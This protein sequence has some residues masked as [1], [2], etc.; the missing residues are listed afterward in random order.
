MAKKKKR[1]V[2][3]RTPINIKAGIVIFGIIFLYV[4]INVIIY[5]ATERVTYYEVIK[6]SVA[7]DSQYSYTAIALRNESVSYAESS[8]YI[9][10]YARENSRVSKNTTL[11]SIDQSGKINELLAQMSDEEKNL[12]DDNITT[13]KEQL[14]S[15]ITNYDEMNYGSVYDFKSSLQGTVVELINM[16]AL[17][18]IYNSLGSTQSEQFQICKPGNSGIVEYTIDNFENLT[19][20]KLKASYFDKANY[21]SARI[22]SGDLVEEGAPIYKTATQEEW[23]L[24]IPLSDEDAKAYENAIAVNIRFKKDNTFVT[25]NFEIVKGSDKK[26]YGI[27]TLQKYMI[28]YADERFLDIEIT[29]R[30][31]RTGTGDHQV[32]TVEKLEGGIEGLKVPKKSVISKDFYVIPVGYKTKGGD[33]EGYGFIKRVYDKSKATDVFTPVSITYQTDEY[34]YVSTD[35]FDAG[36]EVILPAKNINKINVDTSPDNYIA[37]GNNEEETTVDVKS[38]TDTY[39]VT[40]RQTL[41]GVYN[42]NNG[43]TKFVCVEILAETGDYFIIKSTNTYGLIIYDHIILNGSKVKENQVIFQ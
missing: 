22:E 16:N 36:D 17:Q 7:D 23:S 18:N 11:Y 10:F 26:K 31:L 19:A 30:T 2:R 24:A 29:E 27:L 14:Y 20:E 35:E 43:Y 42:I 12:S 28:K 9:N 37:E 5:F 15:F 4:A 6:G 25:T 39:A 8:G 33:S 21:T 13:V 41:Q 32:T 38:L 40:D 1:V 3:Y 34:C